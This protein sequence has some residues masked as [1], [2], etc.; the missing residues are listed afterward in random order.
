M[1]LFEAIRN[2]YS[3]RGE[4]DKNCKVS[5]DE[6]E[7]I[8]T[9]GVLAPSGKNAQTTEFVI[10]DDPQKLAELSMVHTNTASAMIACIVN[11]EPIPVYQDT[12]SF[13]IE[14]CS[15]AVENMLLAITAMGYAS[16]WLDGVLRIDSLAEK[17]AKVIALPENK[18]VR[19]LLPIGK[20][21]KAG[22]RPE[23][24]P[25]KKRTSF[26]TYGS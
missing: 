17:V 25:T 2:R 15:A 3:Y 5:R 1:E 10:I 8:V 4:F 26:N 9:A 13:E 18:I 23:K 24:M 20:P 14:D 11:R 12:M 7:K 6:L 22:Q 16:V 19:V 21:V